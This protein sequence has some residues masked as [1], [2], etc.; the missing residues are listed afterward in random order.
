MPNLLLTIIIFFVIQMINVIMGT[1]RSITTVKG[2]TSSSAIIN[3]IFFG[4]YAIAIKQISEIDLTIT[5]PI[6]IITNM[7]GVY[8][9]N[10][11]LKTVKKDKIWR[12]S[13]YTTNIEEE[14]YHELIQAIEHNG[15]EY[16]AVDDNFID[17]ISYTQK[18]SKLLK[19]LL[20]DYKT[21]V[22]EIEKSL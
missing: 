16:T 4:F 2:S 20:K 12:I 7:I 21:Y 3:A 8:I 11:I 18:D 17:I 6:I 9:A 22:I 13:C 15:F 10:W 1:I 14:A 5:I 19:L